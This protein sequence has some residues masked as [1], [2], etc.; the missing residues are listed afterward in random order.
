MNL[1]DDPWIPVLFETGSAGHV[2]LREA[3]SQGSD[4]ADLTVRPHERIALMRLLICIAQAALDGPADRGEWLHCR[5]RIPDAAQTYLS[6]WRHAFELFGNG[7]RFLQVPNLEP[8]PDCEP[9]I[10]MT[11]LDVAMATGN[12]ATLFDNGGGAERAFQPGGAALALLT[13]QCFSPGG[14]IGIARWAGK[15]TGNGSSDHA[16]CISRSM[17]HTYVRG[18][19]LCAT[20]HLNALHK[21]QVRQL[22]S[23]G[24]A[25]WERL[26]ESQADKDRVVNATETY[27][28]RLVPL[29]RAIRLWP[30]SERILNSNALAYPQHREVASTE[31]LDENPKGTGRT[32]VSA[33]VQKGIWRELSAITVKRTE[34][35]GPLSL[36]NLS[37]DEDFDIWTGGLVASKA[38][39]VDT[40]ESV[41]HIPAAMAKEPGQRTYEAG[42]KLAE[43]ALQRVLRAISAYW[44][45][46]SRTPGKKPN[47]EG[48]KEKVSGSKQT[49]ERFFWTAVEQGLPDLLATVETGAESWS[50]TSWEKLVQRTAR[51]SVGAACPSGTPRQI[52]A[53]SKALQF[54]FSKVRNGKSNNPSGSAKNR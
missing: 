28:G 11:K 45:E 9:D 31:L 3:F 2:S 25:V 20:V 8:Q 27:L 52:R 16:P 23:W 10:P 22:I 41:F 37:D 6:R 12:N 4:I 5:E 29:S 30:N 53:F 39:L 36:Q 49:A 26:P 43:N 54:L 21:Q 44:R 34:G 13:F 24:C 50:D 40:V 1:V 38:K 17:L 14:R 32:V 15:P 19:D 35:G 46:Y 18:G 33:S 7:Q 51:E 48:L 47:K 42:V